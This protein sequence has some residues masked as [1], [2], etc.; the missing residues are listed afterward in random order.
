M[1]AE[2]SVLATLFHQLSNSTAAM[3][4]ERDSLEGWRF[5]W[6]TF[7]DN[8]VD[9]RGCIILIAL[10]GCLADEELALKVGHYRARGPRIV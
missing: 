2:I 3:L 5:V 1:T 6:L 4:E 8:I 10:Y 7:A 9:I